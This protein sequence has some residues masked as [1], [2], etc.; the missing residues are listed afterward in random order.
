MLPL[1]TIF[2]KNLFYQNNCKDAVNIGGVQIRSA[3][4]NFF[5]VKKCPF[6]YLL[7]AVL[8]S[9]IMPEFIFW[10]FIQYTIHWDKTQMLKKFPL[11]KINVTINALTSFFH[12]LQLITVLLLI[13]NSYISWST[14]FSKTV[15]GIFH[16]RFCLVFIKF[17]IFFQKK[18]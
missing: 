6:L 18:A 13:R 17:Y 9:K 5:V 7:D 1:M 15:Y 8:V 3:L 16:F 11:D 10:K 4:F 14:N 12:E 2:I